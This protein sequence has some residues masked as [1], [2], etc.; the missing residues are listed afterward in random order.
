M[1]SD[2]G[3]PLSELEIVQNSALGAYAIWQFGLG[4]QAEDGRNA[5]LPLAFL[6][7]PL[8]MHGPTL[9]VIGSTQKLSGLALFASKL[10]KERESLLAVHERALSLRRLTL[11]S[12]GMGVA[13][14]LLTV[15][16]DDA[17]FR[18]NQVEAKPKKPALPERLKSMP[19]AADKL[20]NWFARAGVYQVASALM[21]EF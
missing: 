21:V 7:L 8:V 17:T 19:R 9:D 18:A 3:Q 6:V 14:S 16:Y 5:P 1:V 15:V 12:I 10:G 2:S 11:Q 13:A 20:G 4:Y